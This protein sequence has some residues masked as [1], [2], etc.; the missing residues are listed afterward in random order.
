MFVYDRMMWGA[1]RLAF[2]ALVSAAA[3]SSR[4]PARPQ[5]LVVLDTDAPVVGQLADHSE[6]SPDGAIDTVRVDVMDTKNVTTELRDFVV[7]EKAG[8]PISFG[9]Q[10]PDVRLAGRVRLRIR[11]F[12]GRLAH[13]GT[14]GDAGTLESPPE[15]TIDRLVDLDAPTSGV[16][17]ILVRIAADCLGM[18]PNFLEPA[19]TCIDADHHAGSPRDGV[20][21]IADDLL[22][23]TR[24]GTWSG[25]QE[26][27]CPTMAA[28][29]RVCIPG[30]FT[31]LGDLDFSGVA[32]T[33]SF[34][35]VPLRPALLSPFHLDQTEFTVGRL[36]ALVQKGAF[37]FTGTGAGPIRRTP[38]DPINQ[39]CTWLG[40]NDPANDTLPVN[41]ILWDDA[42]A[43]CR[44]EGGKLPSEAQWE[45]AARGRGRRQLYPWGN[46]AAAC[47]TTSG[48]RHGAPQSIVECP[49]VGVEPVGSH[50][51]SATCGGIGDVS[52][53]GVLDLAGSVGEAMLDNAAN[54]SDPCWRKTA[55]IQRDPVCLDNGIISRSQRGGS[56]TS[57]LAVGLAPL[58]RLYATLVPIPNEGFRCAYSAGSP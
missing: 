52:R 42:E 17:R 4:A 41:C 13:G 56:W 18:Q 5:L 20:A 24:A 19:T 38:S 43:A 30:G 26:V 1:A 50:R 47:C 48:S 16:R 7:P 34:D 40:E 8:W 32:D 55:G 46:Q 15:V 3:C 57:G 36:R 39:F 2:A 21:E 35:S 12:R 9:V 53:D 31:I 44:S 51:P 49:G 27:P 45:H 6:L 54:F 14:L 23:P 37:A 58:R 22:P 11:A 29:D 10:T 28:S 25:A 33:V